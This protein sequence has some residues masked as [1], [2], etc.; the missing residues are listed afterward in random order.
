MRSVI[1]TLRTLFPLYG[2]DSAPEGDIE[3]CSFW[4]V[5]RNA[6]VVKGQ[7]YL[8]RS[9]NAE[10]AHLFLTERRALDEVRGASF[11]PSVKKT[12]AG[13]A[14]HQIDD[15]VYSLLEEGPGKRAIAITDGQAFRAGKLLRDIHSGFERKRGPAFSIQQR[16]AQI[17]FDDLALR[18]QKRDPFVAQHLPRLPEWINP[19]ERFAKEEATLTHGAFT[20]QNVLFDGQNP[21]G[22]R[23]FTHGVFDGVERDLAIGL[24][25]F[26]LRAD[27]SLDE[28]NQRAFSAGYRDGFS[29][30]RAK[31]LAERGQIEVALYALSLHNKDRMALRDNPQA[32]AALCMWVN[33]SL[34]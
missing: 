10:D 30:L 21:V 20:P 26:G 12:L 17:D 25:T 3:D 22:V 13:E 18:D 8:L 29:P 6:F 1:D 16:C 23:G 5:E 27:G 32:H 11:S 24:Y 19:L 7:R 34:N 33:R 15:R 31:L 4:G 28:T 9:V 14:F 2:I